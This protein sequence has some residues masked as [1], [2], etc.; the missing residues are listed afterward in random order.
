MPIF[1]VVFGILL[2]TKQIRIRF[3]L[4]LI[5]S[6][7]LTISP[8]TIRNFVVFHSSIPLSLGMGTTFVE[9]LGDYDSECKLGLPKTD[10]GV[11]KMDALRSNRPDY[12]GGLYNPDGVEKER[13]RTKFGLAVVKANPGWYFTSVVHRG[14]TGIRMERMPVIAPERDEK[15]TTNPI[16]YGLN[17][18]LKWFQK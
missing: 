14:I 2:L 1:F 9:S 3:A 5:A 18:P 17:I 8:I 7:I 6:F 11:M 13:E 15:E 10:E 16:L 4:V 12:N